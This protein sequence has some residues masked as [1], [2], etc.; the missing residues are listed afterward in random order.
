LNLSAIYAKPISRSLFI[1]AGIEVSRNVSN[2]IAIDS[3]STS[4]DIE[5]DSAIVVNATEPLYLS[6]T[7]TLTTKTS[8]S[9]NVYNKIDRLGIPVLIGYQKVFGDRRI[10]LSAG[11]TI[12]VIRKLRGYSISP[13]GH[14]LSY[15]NLNQEI[16]KNKIINS[17]RMTAHYSQRLTA[18][19]SCLVGG[20]YIMPIGSH[21]TLSSPSNETF[22]KNI[23]AYGIDLGILYDF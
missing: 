17:I 4:M 16:E 2:L 7:R 8:R 15:T 18:N 9:Y 12:N 3:F 19:L 6:G 14:I 5:A 22:E 13:D 20:H 21:Y 11:T 23:H 10:M 1:G